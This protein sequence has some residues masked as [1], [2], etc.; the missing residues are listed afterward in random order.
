MQNSKENI[1]IKILLRYLEGEPSDEDKFIVKQWLSDSQFETELN[2]KSFQF[3][4]GISQDPKIKGYNGNHI[5]DRIHHKIKIEEQVFLKKTNPKN[6]YINY[7]TRI[8]AILF[9]PLLVASLFFYFRNNSTDNLVSYTEI[10]APIG[11]RTIFYLPDGS[12]G[13]LNGGSSLKFPTQFDNKI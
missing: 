8:A 11:T 6:R 12:T 4:D 9:I 2:E 13:L 1:D 3:W 7:L 10:H 5:L